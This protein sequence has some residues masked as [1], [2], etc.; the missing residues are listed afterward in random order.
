MLISFQ[1][2]LNNFPTLMKLLNPT[3]C[4][5]FFL[6]YMIHKSYL[7]VMV[8]LPCTEVV[9]CGVNCGASLLQLAFSLEDDHNLLR[10]KMY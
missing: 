4:S 10:E 7:I 3:N 1:I 5:L 6:P 8:F 2:W 9:Q